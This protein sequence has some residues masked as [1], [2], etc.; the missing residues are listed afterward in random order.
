MGREASRFADRGFVNL[1]LSLAARRCTVPTRKA[2]GL[3]IAP[4]PSGAKLVVEWSGAL[5]GEQPDGAMVVGI[6]GRESQQ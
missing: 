3:M 2:T 1:P 6:I 5:A 4:L